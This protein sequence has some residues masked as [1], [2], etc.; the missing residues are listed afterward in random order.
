MNPVWWQEPAAQLDT[1][2][3]EQ[4]RERQGHL[5]KPPG[6]LGRLEQFAIQLAGWQGSAA[7]QLDNL[8]ISIFAGDHGVVAEGVSAAPQA[9][10]GQMLRNF[11]GGGAAISVM[12]RQLGATLDLRNL[13]LAEPI[14]E[15]AGVHDLNIAPGTANF[16]HQPAMTADQCQQALLAGDAA[17]TEAV[18]RGSQLFIAG[19]MGI[20]NTTAACAMACL[21]LDLPVSALVGP[22]TGVSGDA[23]SHK[24][25]VIEQ[26]VQLHRPEC[27]S[28]LE[29]L[30]RVGGLEIAAI[31]GA[32]LA[33]A[34]QGVPMLVDGYICSTAALC[35]VRM[36]PACRD[37]MLFAHRSAEPGH[38]A[39][40]AALDADPVLDLS[41]RLGE[42][43]GAAACVPLLRLACALHNDMATFAEAAV[44]GGER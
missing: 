31:T 34:Q 42:G 14:G 5:T 2:A 23:L 22:G 15:L 11:A 29:I 25:A 26:A 16:L 4:A 3:Q 30:T 8:W 1:A 33:A 37:W 40:L 17:L 21:L 24:A 13:G 28:P 19:E 12:A 44:S 7:P 38:G 39:V 27:Q 20:G 41:M 35:A 18:E 43:T 10:T 6:A 9:V 32:Y 36:N